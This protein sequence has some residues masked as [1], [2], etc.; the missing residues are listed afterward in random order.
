MG[1]GSRDGGIIGVFFRTKLLTS[2]CRSIVV[3]GGGIIT[4][5]QLRGHL[6][7]HMA[8]ATYEKY[9]LLKWSLCHTETQCHIQLTE[10]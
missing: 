7:V 3:P 6:L 5:T 1:Q 2:Q 4:V 9:W 10:G 8:K